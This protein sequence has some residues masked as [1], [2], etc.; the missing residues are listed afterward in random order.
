MDFFGGVPDMKRVRCNVRTCS[1]IWI[2]QEDGSLKRETPGAGCWGGG[3]SEISAEVRETL[4]L[5]G[6]LNKEDSGL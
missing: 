6:L 2:E 4:D 5:H 1:V 3:K